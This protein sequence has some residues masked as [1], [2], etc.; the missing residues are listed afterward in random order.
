MPLDGPVEDSDLE[1]FERGSEWRKWD[2]HLHTPSSYDYRDQDISNEEIIQ[3]LKTNNISAAAITDHHYIDVDRIKEL[4]DLG[5]KENILILPG[6]ELRSELGGSETVHFIGIFP[7]EKIDNLW[8]KIQGKLDLTDDDIEG[9]D[10]VYKDL[11]DS[12]KI[13]HELGG[14]TT[15]H[16]GTKS[17]SIEKIKNYFSHKQKQKEDLLKSS[18]DILEIGKEENIADY[19]DIVF[20]FI[21]FKAPLIIGSDNHNIKDYELKQNCWIKADLTFEGLKQIIYEPEE[22]VKIQENQPDKKNDYAVI[23]SIKF[24]DNDFI[25]SE[26]ALNNNLV[27][28]IGGRSTGKSIFLRSIARAIDIDQVDSKTEDINKLINPKTIVKWKNGNQDTFDNCSGNKIIY[29][30]Q[31]FL[32]NQITEADPSSFSHNLLNDILKADEDY[33]EIFSEIDS[34]IYNFETT[35]QNKITKLFDTEDKLTELK[36]QLKDLGNPHD[37]QN[38]IDKLNQEYND[39]QARNDV[40][41]DDKELQEILIKELDKIKKEF[42]LLNTDESILNKSL[43]YLTAKKTFFDRD[44]IQNLSD[45]TENNIIPAIE[46]ADIIYKE[47]LI[48]LIHEEVATV[49]NKVKKILKEITEKEEKLDVLNK[50]LNTSELAEDKFNK[51]KE[52][53]TR[54]SLISNKNEEIN[55]IEELKVNLLK[56]IFNDYNSFIQTFRTKESKFSFTEEYENFKAELCFKIKE[57]RYLIENSLN[58]RKFNDFKEEYGF[59]LYEFNYDEDNFINNLETIVNAVLEEFLKTKGS[60]SKKNLIKELLGV[61]HFINFNIIE[62]EEELG[63]M[64]PGKKSFALLKVLIESDKSR[65]PILLDQPEDDLDANSISKSLARFLKEKKKIRQIVIVSHNPNLVVGADSEQVIIANQEGTDLKNR[66]KR[67]EY[68]AGSIE[69]MYNN[70]EEPCYLYCKGIKEHV[71]DILEGGEESFKKRQNKYN[72]E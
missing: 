6:I 34:L 41:S 8:T 47:R 24:E 58:K 21:G 39:L 28:I 67:F 49:Q 46:Q 53:T 60:K 40:S 59:D 4:A 71:C 5:R 61:Y 51:I 15:V 20:P 52:E 25:D 37:V 30:P 29:I 44:I 66:S 26:I 56:K 18:I 14:I 70:E 9:H 10:K 33:K 35:T 13:F 2:L 31:N 64:S 11:A 23:D 54:L 12:C 63:S 7:L 65:W 45:Y 43:D 36:K 57:F 50:K 68:I 1:Y 16:A 19:E 3:N 72:I 69:N 48:N 55:K 62:D 32:N 42:S 27:S 38:E 22:R 17:N